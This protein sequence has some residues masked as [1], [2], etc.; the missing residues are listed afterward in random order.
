MTDRTPVDGGAGEFDID[1][2]A[3]GYSALWGLTSVDVAVFFTTLPP[4]N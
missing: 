1:T 2:V 3:A 4:H